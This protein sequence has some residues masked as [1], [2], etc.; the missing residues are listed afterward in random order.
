MVEMNQGLE[1]IHIGESKLS[2]V[3]G[4]KGE[5]IYRGYTIEDLALN[6]TFEDTVFLL[7]FGVLPDADERET[8]REQIALS[9]TLPPAVVAALEA[10]KDAHPMD[11]IRT[12]VSLLGGID[13]ASEDDSV[14]ANRA[15]SFRLIGQ[16][17]A[18]VAT[19]HRIR[20]GLPPLDNNPND[21][22]ARYFMRSIRDEEP[23]DH[24]VRV[25]DACL[26]LHADH[27]CNASTF[28]ARVTTSTMSDLHSAVVSAIG[29]LKGA[30][31]GGANSRVMEMLLTI[32]SEDEAEAFVDDALAHKRRIMGFGHRVYKVFDPR[33]KVLR[34]LSVGMIGRGADEKWLRMSDRMVEVMKAK[35]DIDPNVDFYSASLYYSMGIPLDIYTPIFAM[36]R[37]SGWCAHILEQKASNRLMRP[38]LVYTGPRDLTTKA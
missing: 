20:E 22:M 3:D 27:G 25:F 10:C 33:A 24:F 4:Q 14:E 2:S 21:D 35:K 13:S 12:A 19:F 37:V 26:T 9:R 38:R 16:L 11:A 7:F 1:G 15:K 5:L 18:A 31:H 36:S 32:G 29:T 17:G 34:E 6:R 23:D 30:L 28:S 8:L